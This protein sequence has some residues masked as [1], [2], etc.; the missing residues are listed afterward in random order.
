M[1]WTEKDGDEDFLTKEMRK[2]KTEAEKPEMGHSP[3]GKA[4]ETLGSW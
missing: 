2:E 4:P 3:G 1:E